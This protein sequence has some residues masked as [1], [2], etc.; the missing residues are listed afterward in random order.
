MD[1]A[2]ITINEEDCRAA[3]GFKL[4]QGGG[5]HYMPGVGIDANRFTPLGS[6][7][8]KTLRKRLGFSEDDFVMLF[9]AELNHNK[10]QDLLI[11]AVKLLKDKGIRTIL[12]LAG[13][14]AVKG[15]YKKLAG[16]LGLSR[17]V[18]FL[19][20]RD[21]IDL[22]L[23]AADVALS[24]SRRKGLPLNIMEA[25][26]AGLPV[27][28]TSCRGNRDLVRDGENGLLVRA[29]DV[30]G[31]VRSIELL[32]KSKEFRQTLGEK[33]RSLVKAY[34]V[35]RVLS[36]LKDIY[37][38]YLKPKGKGTFV[39]SLDTELAWGSFD[40]GISKRQ[41]AALLATRPC[42]TKL[43]ML[44]KE[45][46][47]SATFAFIGHLMLDRCA[48][49]QG[50]KHGNLVRPD[51]SWYPR[52]WFSEDPASDI[53]EAPLWYG[54]DIL[55]Q[56][57][58]AQPKHEIG[59][60]SFSHII[61]G[62]P[63][64]SRACAES[65]LSECVQTADMLD[66]KLISFVYPRN[67][68]GHK[69]LLFRYGFRIYRGLGN[70]WFQKIK[71][72]LLRKLCHMIDQFLGL[73]PETSLPFK[74]ESGLYNTVGNMLYMSRSGIR[75]LIPVTSRVRKAIRG[76]DR[77]IEKGEVFHLWFHPSDLASDPKGLLSGLDRIF[78]YVRRKIDEGVLDNCTMGQLYERYGTINT[79]GE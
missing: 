74:E 52:D 34:T 24:S 65:D 62:A 49:D 50:I 21:D 42:I 59:C 68:A 57:L 63:G 76:I 2:I 36:Y 75:R 79:S 8:R 53:A 25:M 26:A 77:A 31:F 37:S 45:H 7:E 39:L 47:I 3:Q 55:L 48:S 66:L 6:D 60:H 13:R 56:V 18:F 70:E 22:L 9:A 71:N 27:V 72:S 11:R 23:R 10:H 40:L 69:D 16:K 64:C 46:N 73:V 4:R 14:D 61:Y 38:I 30:A 54:R 17:E 51:F 41:R 35:D 67:H 44:L 28:A 20:E 58:E 78:S 43:L 15:K 5:I 29:D 19:G 12:L 33:G 1:Y 32:Y